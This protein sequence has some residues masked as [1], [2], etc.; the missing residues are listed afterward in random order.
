MNCA[1]G[2]VAVGIY[3]LLAPAA[4]L[5]ASDPARDSFRSSTTSTTSSS[6]APASQSAGHWTCWTPESSTFFGPQASTPRALWFSGFCAGHIWRYDLKTEKIQVF[7]ALDGLPFDEGT[8]GRIATASDER[9]AVFIRRNGRGDTLFLWTPA[10]GWHALPAIG[11]NPSAVRDIGFDAKDQLLA[12]HTQGGR[13]RI[14]RLDGKDW[15]AV[16]DVP[17]SYSLVPLSEGCLLANSDNSATTTTYVPA[18]NPDQSTSTKGN[19]VY[20]S[21][22]YYFRCGSKV[23]CLATEKQEKLIYREKGF[24]VTPAGFRESLAGKYIGVDLKAG[25]FFDCRVIES[26]D[27]HVVLEPQV[28]DAPRIELRYDTDYYFQPIRDPNGHLWVGR[29]R[30]D[31]REWKTFSSGFELPGSG[32]D[33][34][35]QPRVRL[36]ADGT[37]WNHINP[38]LPVRVRSYD[39]ATRTG[40]TATSSNG[41]G[42]LRLTR[43]A[44]G[45]KDVIRTVPYDD[46]PGLPYFRTASGDWWWVGRNRGILRMTPEGIREYPGRHMIFPGPQGNIWCMQHDM[47]SFRYDAGKDEFV[48]DRQVL[49]DFAFDLGKL[50]L[51]WVPPLPTLWTKTPRGDWTEFR[52]PFSDSVATVYRSPVYKDRLLLS[53]G[54]IGVLEYN[55][56]L[57]RWIRLSDVGY[58]AGFDPQGRRLLHNFCILVYDGD[59]WTLAPSPHDDEF[60]QLLKQMDDNNWNVREEATRLMRENLDRFRWQI[61]QA[62]DD[63]SLSEEVRS[64][65]K[66]LLPEKDE[67]TKPNLPPPPLFRTMHP[68][69]KP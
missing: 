8:V 7:S 35:D 64:R 10:N 59:P 57:D 36:S 22:L 39:P 65:L 33:A 6:S 42:E 27:E 32:W 34:L 21:F 37:H 17:E 63:P 20:L 2:G 9:C 54:G 48:P 68:L 19:L 1:V 52:T 4:A 14:S 30:W 3:L 58:Y 46:F 49:E 28:P 67:G 47:S 15:V 26:T 11:D 61:F 69:L 43:F 23:L 50:R 44:D 55:A 12:L 53:V 51:S 56:T 25:G 16:R 40:W 38:D 31:G 62:A 66:G 29:R 45:K 5:L 60:A 41:K 13:Y 18:S 24:E